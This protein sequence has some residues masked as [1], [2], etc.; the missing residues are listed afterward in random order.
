MK[1]WLPAIDAHRKT[2]NAKKGAVIFEEGAPVEGIYF[3]NEGKAKVHKKWDGEKE[4]IVRI[5]GT[6]AILGHRGLGKSLFYPVSATALEPVS[7]CFIDLDFFYATTK[8]NPD[9]TFRLMMFFAEE[10]Q[11][12]EKNMRN[13]AHMTVKGRLAQTLLMLQ[14]KFGKTPDGAINIS[15]SRQDIA[16]L[17]GATY[18]TVFRMMSELME[19][20]LIMTNN[21]SITINDE[22]RLKAMRN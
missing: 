19:E 10:L 15:L 3:I 11:E 14:E 20:K 5:A 18:E 22:E 13:L 21:K 8:V 12:S 2:I 16:S 9:F 4:L 7:L 1:E 17:T 6:G